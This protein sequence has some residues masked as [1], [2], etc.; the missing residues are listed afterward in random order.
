MESFTS[1]FRPSGRRGNK[2]SEGVGAGAPLRKAESRLLKG[3]RGEH[4]IDFLFIHD[5]VL[6]PDTQWRY[7]D[8][9]ELWPSKLF[10]LFPFARIF[11]Y[12][13]ER[14]WVKSLDDIVD[15]K[16]I[17]FVMRR[18]RRLFATMVCCEVSAPDIL[19][20]LKSAE[21]INFDDGRLPVENLRLV[22][23][24]NMPDL[25]RLWDYGQLNT[26]YR[27]QW[28]FLA[29]IF[30]V[31]HFS[32][33]T[34]NEDHILPF[35]SVETL[36]QL[37]GHHGDE[38]FGIPLSHLGQVER[39]GMNVAEHVVLKKMDVKE[40]WQNITK[41]IESS[42]GSIP[43]YVAKP[44]VSFAIHDKHYI[45]FDGGL[46]DYWVLKPWMTSSAQ[47]IAGDLHQ[48]YELLQNLDHTS[49]YKYSL[50]LHPGSDTE[51]ILNHLD[52]SISPTF[53]GSLE[54]FLLH[55]YDQSYQTWSMCC[56]V[57]EA[58]VYTLYGY[59]EVGKLRRRA[60]E[61]S[62]HSPKERL[63][64]EESMCS[65]LEV[66]GRRNYTLSY[67]GTTRDGEKIELSALYIWIQHI[68]SRE[69]ECRRTSAIRDVLD[70]VQ[71]NLYM[72]REDDLRAMGDIASQLYPV[73]EKAKTD[74]QY[75]FLGQENKRTITSGAWLWDAGA[76]GPSPP[77]PRQH[78]VQWGDW[79]FILEN[80]FAEQA[81]KRL[82][83]KYS[84]PLS[85]IT[86]DLCDTC[87]TLDFAGPTFHISE[88]VSNLEE[89]SRRCPLCQMLLA[90]CKRIDDWD[91]TGLC[92]F[93]RRG[94]NIYLSNTVFPP[95]LSLSRNLDLISKY[96]VQI[97]FPQLPI[98]GD[99]TFELIKTWLE[100]CDKN[101]SDC[102]PHTK[103]SIPRILID[104]SQEAIRLDKDPSRGD[105][106]Y[107]ALSYRRASPME[108]LPLGNPIP[109]EH[110][111]NYA[112]D[113]QLARLPET[114]QDAVKTTRGLG[115][116]YLW[117]DILCTRYVVDYQ[118]TTDEIFS[119]A[120][121]VLVASRASSQFTGFLGQRSERSF[122][123][124]PDKSSTKGQLYL[125]AP[126]DDFNR[127]VMQSN[128]HSTARG[129]QQRALATRSIFFG[130]KQLYLECGRGIR[131]ETLSLIHNQTASF[132]GDP[133]FPS[134]A[135]EAP[136]VDRIMLFQSLYVHL[137]RLYLQSAYDRP[138]GTAGIE[139]R[140]AGVLQCP[141]RNGIFEG[142]LIHYSLL[143]CRHKEESRLK[144][145][146]ES[147]L[148]ESKSWFE[149]LD[150]RFHELEDCW[151]QVSTENQLG[152][153][154]SQFRVFKQSWHHLLGESRLQGLEEDLLQ[155]LESP[156]RELKSWFEGLEESRLQRLQVNYLGKLKSRF[157]ELE[158]SWWLALQE[159]PL[160]GSK[161]Q[162]NLPSWSWQA[163]VGRIDYI[164]P[165]FGTVEWDSS[166]RIL[167]DQQSGF[168]KLEINAYALRFHPPQ[169]SYPPWEGDKQSI[170]YDDPYDVKGDIGAMCVILGRFNQQTR[171][172]GIMYVV[173]IVRCT[174]PLETCPYKR[175]GAGILDGGFV[176]QRGD[177]PR[178]PL[179]VT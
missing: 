73:A 163:R 68:Q 27:I 31:H 46:Q 8:S 28:G 146:N 134:K 132:L 95:V 179:V 69:L 83:G 20:A 128:L 135:L 62:L 43:E 53:K 82:H 54:D 60:C 18:A 84:L 44:I 136:L 112:D 93:E 42:W 139:R 174:G 48:V 137:S 129:F 58:V 141:S 153:S 143:W 164:A 23:R 30:S 47:R 173:L 4:K 10:E 17:H 142:G 99:R 65:A 156:L 66:K 36:T 94:S 113:I 154:E 15:P 72:M 176:E 59:K 171:Y 34:F 160:W 106:K 14:S 6:D 71:N 124:I 56:V 3:G 101:H 126:I 165:D 32:S 80:D 115:I 35:V 149:D 90:A 116:R 85:P 166:I 21:A 170:V 108:R 76:L 131:C 168:P 77:Y 157:G 11:I 74:E 158:K 37:D 81:M 105:V 172:H 41:A 161:S 167:D 91:Q 114:F 102:Q 12:Q 13:Y 67:L 25:F 177:Y 49:L 2:I 86:Q 100:Y 120:Y 151:G 7:R 51:F 19:L 117:I 140:L 155:K 61:G 39:D 16:H 147:R 107:A 104:V 178:D 24:N 118:T 122:I 89:R 130:E 110:D 50:D 123:T 45:M 79:Q 103:T 144:G 125:C 121:C 169:R 26:F 40:E 5:A 1:L 75:A 64:F 162:P 29:P 138:L 150:S 63:R 57:L 111:H 55:Y 70:L 92:T 78:M 87:H 109:I 96:S 97:G 152:E 38:R 145:L 175:I 148:E 33:Q 127:D 22:P 88:T 133:A 52:G 119:G 9:D 98:N 159:S